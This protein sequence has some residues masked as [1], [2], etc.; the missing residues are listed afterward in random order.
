MIRSS[1]KCICGLFLLALLAPLGSS[2]R[3]DIVFVLDPGSTFTSRTGSTEPLSGTFVW[4]TTYHDS[5]F[6]T[7]DATS[8]NF[9]TPTYSFS[10]DGT[11]ANNVESNAFISGTTYFEEVVDGSSF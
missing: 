4:H 10:L 6:V 7:F 3:G 9:N 1:V 8:L 11:A 5:G 2:A